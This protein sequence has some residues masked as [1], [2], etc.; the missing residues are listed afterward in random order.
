MQA[1]GESVFAPF[2]LQN[3]CNNVILNQQMKRN[4]KKL[5]SIYG[6]QPFSYNR[7]LKIWKAIP[8]LTLFVIFLCFMGLCFSFFATYSYYTV[9]GPSMQPLLNNYTSQELIS[10]TSDGVYVNTTVK[11]MVGDIVVVHRPN[12][13]VKFVIKR[14][15]AVGGD[16]IAIKEVVLADGITKRYE[17]LRIP[18]GNTTPYV[19]VENYVREEN[20]VV[21]M[22]SVYENFQELMQT[23]PNK[24]VIDNTVFL[25]LQEDEIFY[26]GDNRGNSRDC[27]EYGP[28]K[29]ENLVGRVD[30]IVEKEQNMLFH[31]IQYLLGFKTI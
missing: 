21:G 31:I 17:V 24:Q 12:E 29:A 3:K 15:M 5:K 16:K 30:I 26:M 20:K 23:Q 18:K 10:G 8:D 7:A 25:V 9:Q 2:I 22:K 27:S 14:L 6:N 28:V 19:V 11:P 4:P 13:Q 1:K